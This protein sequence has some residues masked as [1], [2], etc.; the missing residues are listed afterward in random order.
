MTTAEGEPAVL[1]QDELIDLL[2]D[3]L[4]P[5]SYLVI[6]IGMLSRQVRIDWRA[7]AKEHRGEVRGEWFAFRHIRSLTQLG[8]VVNT[9]YRK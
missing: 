4:D 1:T 5:D 6:P 3:G 7:V 9:R 8:H 2:P